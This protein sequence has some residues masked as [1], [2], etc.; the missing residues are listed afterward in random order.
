MDKVLKNSWALFLGMGFIMMA[1]GFQGSLLGVRAV[2]EDFSLTSTGF[3][4]SGYFVG[5][6]IGAATI[7]QII[8]R[9][10]HIRVFAAFAS[11][12]SLVI[13]IHSVLINP[14]VWFVLRVLTGIS[15]VC[16]YTVAESWLNDRS[17]NK[18]RGS[19]LSVYMV[20]LYGSMGIGMFLLN[21]SKPQNFQPFILISV[22]T[23]A[24]LIPILLTKKKP[25][26]FKKI[27]AMSLKN[28]YEASPFGMVSSLFYGTIQS[29][30][31][32]L[33]AVYATSMNF[34]ILEIS[35]VTFL[36]AV[37]GAVAQFP[38]GKISDIY[39][40]RKVIVLSTFSAAVF[41]LLAILVSRQMYLPEGLATSKTWFYIFFILFSF[42]SLPMFSL[43]LAHTNDYISKDKFVAA[44][45]GLQFA[46]GLGAISGPFLCSLFMDIVGPNGFFIFLFFFHSIIGVFGI[47]RMKVRQT[48]DNPD[49]QFVAMPQTITPAGIELNPITEPIDEPE[50][51]TENGKVLINETSDKKDN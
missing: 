26:K 38:I 15:M 13:L 49:S 48:I 14:F 36:L 6:F 1:Y 10:G 32:T 2:R 37:S 34:S 41:S 25:P 47:Y 29:A 12:A 9:V 17:S 11:L 40:R 24:A 8:S 42:F 21:F 28:L 51:K 27:K 4:M 5:Y 7:P 23:S 20:I 19:I 45:A 16:I 18:N 30:L 3:M 22:I 50:V 31:F 46:F 43:I 44:G 33:L 35:I 39:D